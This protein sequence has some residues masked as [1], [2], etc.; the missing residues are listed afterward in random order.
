[1]ENNFPLAQQHTRLTGKSHQPM[2]DR[3]LMVDAP[4]GEP[5]T[6]HQ[7]SLDTLHGLFKVGAILLSY[8]MQPTFWSGSATLAPMAPGSAKPM[9]QKP[10]EIWQVFGS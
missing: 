1:M 10:F 8:M 7:G 6:Q 9:V 2:H 4:A 3:K 5:D